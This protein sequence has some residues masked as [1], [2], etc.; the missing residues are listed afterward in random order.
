LGP[1]SRYCIKFDDIALNSVL[2][3][4]EKSLSLSYSGH[5]N[6]IKLEWEMTDPNAPE[7]QNAEEEGYDPVH[8]GELP[9]DGCRSIDVG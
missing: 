5:V 1:R 3:Y 6:L 4:S 2:K 7:H 8:Q 9:I